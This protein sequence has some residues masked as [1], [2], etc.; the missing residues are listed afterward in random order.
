MTDRTGRVEGKYK[1]GWGGNEF[2]ATHTTI[3][4]S[5]NWNQL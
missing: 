1:M 3:L 4:T 2:D 5:K